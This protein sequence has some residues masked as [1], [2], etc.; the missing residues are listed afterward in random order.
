MIL[1]WKKQ[2][3]IADYVKV[4]SNV[5]P[6]AFADYREML[7]TVKPDIV[8]ITTESGKHKQITIDCLNAGCYVIC[9]KPMAL[10]TA[11]AQEMIDIA[12]KII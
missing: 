9:E 2:K 12:K 8:T 3:K 5:K 7:K 4:C 11:N 10:S 1:F 6:Q